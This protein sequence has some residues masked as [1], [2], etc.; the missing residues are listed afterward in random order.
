MLANCLGFSLG[1]VLGD[2]LLNSS[3]A[4]LGTT[5]FLIGACMSALG[6]FAISIFFKESYVPQKNKGK[7]NVFK[8]FS[9]IKI[10]FGKP[11][12]ANYLTTLLFSM[13]A[14]GLFFSDIPIFLSSTITD[15]IALTGTV[16]SSEA[17][18]FSITLMFGGKFVFNYF[19]KTSVVFFTLLIQL[20]SYLILSLCYDS[21]ILNLFLFT[22]ISAFAG[23][24]YIALLTLISDSTESDWQGRIMGVVAALSSVTW[25]VGPLLTGFLNRYGSSLAFVICALFVVIATYSFFLVKVTNKKLELLGS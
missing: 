23:L 24:M 13:V 4:P 16:L 20:I 5:T 3:F 11:Q 8:D 21:F 25:G 15:H 22:V 6:F 7:L 12:L 1:P 2:L 9:N 17:I 18:V 14:F 19:A 10:A